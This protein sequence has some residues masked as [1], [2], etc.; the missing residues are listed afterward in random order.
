VSPSLYSAQ[1]SS[2]QESP[3]SS[4]LA[5]KI[6]GFLTKV[7]NPAREVLTELCSLSKQFSLGASLA[8]KRLVFYFHINSVIYFR[9]PFDYPLNQHFITLAP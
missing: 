4:S 6:L 7:R 2:L 5:R 9:F 8:D 3:N 1:D